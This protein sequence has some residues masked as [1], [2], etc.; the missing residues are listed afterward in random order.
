MDLI[1]LELSQIKDIRQI[2]SNILQIDIN[3]ISDDTS[4]NEVDKW[5]SLNHL[6]ISIEI[7]KKFKIKFSPSEIETIIN[8]KKILNLVELKINYE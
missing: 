7:E 3:D 4:I 6:K 2:L 1:K 5:D 8:Y